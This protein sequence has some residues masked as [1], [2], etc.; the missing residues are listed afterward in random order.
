MIVDRVS[1]QG[2]TEMGCES[3]DD[4]LVGGIPLGGWLAVG[5]RTSILRVWTILL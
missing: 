2:V 3:A 4:L 1:L 5:S